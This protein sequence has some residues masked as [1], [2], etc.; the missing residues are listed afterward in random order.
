MN[1]LGNSRACSRRGMA[2]LGHFSPLSSLF[3]LHLSGRRLDIVKEPF[4]PKQLT[5]QSRPYHKILLLYFIKIF[6]NKSRLIST[7]TV[8]FKRRVALVLCILFT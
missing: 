6:L 7:E 3:F 2:L 1:N 5:I 8:F 4:N